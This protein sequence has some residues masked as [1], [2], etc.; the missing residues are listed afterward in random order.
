MQACKE[1]LRKDYLS[2]LLTEM[3]IWPG[4]QACNFWKV[5]VKHQLLVINAATIVDSTF[6]CWCARRRAPATCINMPYRVCGFEQLLFI[7]Q[8]IF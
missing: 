8:I 1:K 4:Y 6:L 2:T 3:V 7:G 5:P